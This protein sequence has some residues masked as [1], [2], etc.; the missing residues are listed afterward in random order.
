MGSLSFCAIFLFKLQGQLEL[1]NIWE[2]I[3]LMF[4]QDLISIYLLRHGLSFEFLCVEN[5]EDIK[6]RSWN[7]KCIYNQWVATCMYLSLNVGQKMDIIIRQLVPIFLELILRLCK[8]FHLFTIT[9]FAFIGNCI[10]AKDFKWP[11]SINQV[12]EKEIN[13]I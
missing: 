7:Q 3:L 13:Y 9:P 2:K 4:H 1:G 8:K 10:H 12:K 5:Q 11:I 6:S